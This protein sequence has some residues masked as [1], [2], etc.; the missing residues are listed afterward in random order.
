MTVHPL[1]KLFV[2]A[3]AL[4][5]GG[6]AVGRIFSGKKL[7]VVGTGKAPKEPKETKPPK[8]D[9]PDPARA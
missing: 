9:D 6:I 1:A 4:V 7:L 2:I 8:A 5:G 3:A